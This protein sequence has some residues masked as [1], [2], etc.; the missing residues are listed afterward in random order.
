VP[1]VVLGVLIGLVAF[2]VP[3]L[4]GRSRPS[5]P[6]VC[7]LFVES[8]SIRPFARDGG[9][10]AG[11]AVGCLLSGLVRY[12]RLAVGRMSSPCSP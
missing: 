6:R 7:F 5:D 2:A 9:G 3:A 8:T 12:D 1:F 11:R 4:A 10:R